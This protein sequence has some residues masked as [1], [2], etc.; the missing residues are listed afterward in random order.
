MRANGSLGP[1]NEPAPDH[2]DWT[3]V[4]DEPC[5]QCGFQASAVEPEQV[6]A[7]MRANA[8]GFRSALSRGAMVSQRPPVPPGQSARWSALEYGAHV[9]DV[10]ALAAERITRML[11]KKAPTFQNWDQNAA[12]I[13]KGYR[14]EDPDRVSYALAVNAGKTADLLDRVR[15]DQWQ[16]AGMRSDGAGFTLAS[17]AVYMLHDVTHHLWDVEQGYQALKEARRAQ[18][19]AAAD[20][21]A[22][23]TGSADQ[24]DGEPA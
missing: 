21:M 20:Q 5:G 23:G 2:K 3:W 1:M 7:L 16:R 6:A 19:A 22:G 24:Q 12:A 9:R 18:A 13:D 4:L 14:N 17:F 8:A 11:K 15:G 10:Y